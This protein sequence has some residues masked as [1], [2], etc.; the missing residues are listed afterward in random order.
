MHQRRL[1]INANFE[2]KTILIRVRAYG[3]PTGMM[4]KETGDLV[5]DYIGKILYMDLEDNKDA[6]WVFIGL[7]YVDITTIMRFGPMSVDEDE[8][9]QEMTNEDVMGSEEDET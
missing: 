1:Y 4:S 8:E 2:F 5:G 9:D 3:I 6:V 7:M